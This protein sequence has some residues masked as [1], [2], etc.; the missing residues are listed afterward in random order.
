MTDLTTKL[1]ARERHRSRGPTPPDSP[2][3]R[4]LTSAQPTHHH[5]G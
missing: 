1:P 3:R 4:S 5:G 2:L